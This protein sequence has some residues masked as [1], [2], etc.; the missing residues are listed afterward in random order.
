MRTLHL[1]AGASG[2][3]LADLILGHTPI[4]AVEIDPYCCNVLRARIDDGW[5]PELRVHEID[6]RQFD[7]S[8]YTGRV[9]CVAGG[10]PCQDISA[11]GKGAGITGE[12]SG[13]WSEFAR[14][15]R[16]VRPRYAF[17]EN[18]PMLTLRGLD[19][20]LADLAALGFDA[21][22]DVI[23]ASQVGAPHL[24]KRIWIL[25]HADRLRQLQPQGGEREQ[26]GWAGDG[27][28]DVAHAKS[29]RGQQI[30]RS[31]CADA[32]KARAGTGG[33][34]FVE[35]RS[36]TVADA[37]RAGPFSAAQAGIHCGEESPRAQHEQPERRGDSIPNTDETVLQGWRELDQSPAAGEAPARIGHDL[38][39]CSRDGW[40][41]SEPDVGRVAHGVAARVDRLK[42]IGNGQVPLQAALAWRVLQARAKRITETTK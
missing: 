5:F 24:R 21:E 1:F 25:A 31:L 17:I 30:A 37:L 34:Q 12:R 8:E 36:I 28:Q 19:V 6:I 35:C 42:S 39:R 41:Q 27:S 14:V 4:G 15:L 16:V 9:D 23:S 11:A 2:G 40:W 7:P 18:S 38:V 20:V 26:R 22:W 33:H 3:L 29:E 32:G 13:L 10:F